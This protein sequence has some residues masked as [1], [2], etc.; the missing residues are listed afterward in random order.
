[1]NNG[2]PWIKK[3]QL[4]NI[5]TKHTDKTQHTL[6][7]GCLLQKRSAINVKNRIMA[8]GDW[9]FIVSACVTIQFFLSN[10][11]CRCNVAKMKP[12]AGKLVWN[13]CL[14]SIFIVLLQWILLPLFASA[15]KWHFFVGQIYFALGFKNEIGFNYAFCN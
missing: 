8:C 9:K 14:A 5:R 7:Y 11:M 15:N 13:S 12:D 1:M 3:K 2:I 6:K 4:N 10:W